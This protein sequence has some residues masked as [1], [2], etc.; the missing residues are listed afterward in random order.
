[1]MDSW[2]SRNQTQNQE[3]AIS[4][5]LLGCFE[6]EGDSVLSWIVTADKAWISRFEPETETQSM[7]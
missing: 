2:E 7:E 5:E 1:M 3:K 6:G 4:S